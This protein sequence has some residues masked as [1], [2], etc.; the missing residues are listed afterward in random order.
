M[1]QQWIE[2]R[3]VN[4]TS[5]KKPRLTN[6]QRAFVEAY[7][8]TLNATEAASAAR[9]CQSVIAWWSGNVIPRH[10]LDGVTIQIKIPHCSLNALMP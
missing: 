9:L 3:M 10:R 4:K 8:E 7:L 1:L 6:K 5:S 2:I